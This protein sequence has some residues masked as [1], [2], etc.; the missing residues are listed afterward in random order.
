MKF[1]LLLML[2]ALAS[3]EGEGPSLLESPVSTGNNGPTWSLHFSLTHTCGVNQYANFKV[4]CLSGGA[5]TT[6]NNTAGMETA[7]CPEGSNMRL[8]LSGQDACYI[9][10]LKLNGVLA[11]EWDSWN[12]PAPTNYQIDD[13]HDGHTVEIDMTGLG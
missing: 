10:S 13:S 2:F 8:S 7:S 1:S 3:C 9:N 11:P 6:F 5:V 4:E 12:V